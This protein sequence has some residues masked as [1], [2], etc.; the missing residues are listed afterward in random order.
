MRIEEFTEVLASK[1][2]IP[3]GGG[4]SALTAALGIAL[5]SMV[6]NLTVGKKKYKDVEEEIRRQMQQAEV[7]QR[8]LLL[9]IDKDAEA[10]EP[11]SKAYGL[12]KETEEQLEYRNK[13]MEEALLKASLVPLKIM[14]TVLEAIAVLEVMA[15]KGSRIAVSDAGVGVQFCRAALLGASMN[16]FINTKLMKDREKAAQLNQRCEELMEDGVKRADAV[17]ELVMK[18][19]RP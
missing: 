10:F 4:A 15:E 8:E 13:V 17:F 19:I 1:S 7:L 9:F 5:G 2:A 16:V 12:P 11:L 14:E 3:G 18:S 6:G